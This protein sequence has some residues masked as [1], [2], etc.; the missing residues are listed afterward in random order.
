[1]EVRNAGADMAA[2][3][4]FGNAGVRHHARRL[5]FRNIVI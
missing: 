5:R 1:M 3:L 4:K 2:K